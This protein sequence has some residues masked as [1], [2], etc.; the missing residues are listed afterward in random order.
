[1]R[2]RYIPLSPAACSSLKRPEGRNLGFRVPLSRLGIREWILREQKRRPSE[3]ERNDHGLGK[4]IFF[5][6]TKNRGALSRRAGSIGGGL[7]NPRD[8]QIPLFGVVLPC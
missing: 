4:C 2:S 8:S 3:C 6:K 5:G 7:Y 1:M